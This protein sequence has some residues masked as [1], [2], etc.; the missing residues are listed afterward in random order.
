[1]ENETAMPRSP[2]D[3]AEVVEIYLKDVR[4][5]VSKKKEI[6]DQM[7]AEQETMHLSADS[8]RAVSNEFAEQ[9][10]IVS[11][12]DSTTEVETGEINE[13]APQEVE[14]EETEVESRYA[15]STASAE[16]EENEDENEVQRA[17]ESAS[18]IDSTYLERGDSQV[19]S[20]EFRPGDY[21]CTC[22]AKITATD[23]QNLLD[24]IGKHKKRKVKCFFADCEVMKEMIRTFE[25]HLDNAHGLKSEDLNG[26]QK[27]EFE[28]VKREF[29]DFMRKY[30]RHYFQSLN[31][32]GTSNNV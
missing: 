24:H 32:A 26:E 22:K 1:M 15:N 9:L 21:T 19:R 31:Q 28:R 30:L 6:I 11:G 5:N 7:I 25:E 16:D 10:R 3:L 4:S 23:M 14:E 2:V 13:N 20:Q 29:N 8:L 27:N 12:V 18:T 17:N